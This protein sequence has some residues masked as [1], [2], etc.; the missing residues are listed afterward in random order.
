MSVTIKD[1]AEQL[2]LSVSTISKAL[3]AY[4]HVAEETRRRVLAKA[5]ELGYRPSVIARG[6]QARESRMIGYSWR[7]APPDQFNPILEKFIHS[8]A[9]AAARH[10]YH[11]LTFPCPEPYDELGVYR[12]MV[13]S[14]R[15]DGF[16]LPN[17]NL[18]DRRIRYLLDVDFPFVA[19][20]RSNSEWDFPW[21]DVDGTDGVKQAVN[22][23][24]ELG[25][26][27]VA[28]LAWPEASLTGRYRLDGYLTAMADAGLSVD[29]AWIMR[30]EYNYYSAYQAT[31]T[32]LTLPPERWPTAV[33]ALADLIAIGVMNA[34]AA[35]GLQVGR[36]LAVVGF[37]DAPIA[38]YLRPSLTSLRQPI[39]EVGERAVTMLIDLVR[40]ETPSPAQVLLKPRL[41][42]R[43][44]TALSSQS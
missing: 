19:F 36:E 6:L 27:R 42:V 23:L 9:E 14:G 1:L 17:T 13:G 33:V 37:D 21:V 38:G 5:E 31:Q 4:P 8:M 39:A 7:P 16:I 3:N 22:H 34:A 2:N 12:E 43:E 29:P 15:V 44:S 25:H 41:I 40:G 32:W 30:I 26:R 28:C 11:I 10:D 20:G 24:L 35:A 18:N